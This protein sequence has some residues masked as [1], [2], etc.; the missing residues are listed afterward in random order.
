MQL[1]VLSPVFLVLIFC[2]VDLADQGWGM[3]KAKNSKQQQQ[4]CMAQ[5]HD[6]GQEESTTSC[7][8]QCTNKTEWFVKEKFRCYCDSDCKAFEDCCS[9]YCTFCNATKND[10]QKNFRWKCVKLGNYDSNNTKISDG[11]WMVAQCASDWPRDS[12][13]KKYKD[14]KEATIFPDIHRT[15]PIL[16]GNNITFRNVYCALCNNITDAYDPWTFDIATEVT[17]PMHFNFTE[18]IHFYIAHEAEFRRYR[19]EPHQ[20]RRYCSGGPELHIN[21]K[22]FSLVLNFQ[23]FEGRQKALEL[24]KPKCSTGL[25][26]DEKLQICTINWLPPSTE[27]GP[28]R[29]RVIFWLQTTQK[30]EGGLSKTSTQQALHAYFQ[31]FP[32]NLNVT[33]ITSKNGFFL[34]KSTLI[35]TPEQSLELRSKK[36]DKNSLPTSKFLKLIYFKNAWEM[37]ISNRTFKVFKTTSRPLKCFGISKVYTAGE[38]V[39]LDR[40]KIFVNATNNTYDHTNYFI[41]KAANGTRALGNITVCEKYIPTSCKLWKVLSPGHFKIL[42]NL[43]IYENSTSSLYDYGKYEVLGNSIQICISLYNK[44]SRH[45]KTIGKDQ[46][47]GWITIVCFLVSII[48][49]LALLTTYTMF[50]ELRK[51][52]GKNLMNLATSSLMSALFWLISSFTNPEQY[53]KFC[54]ATIIIQHYSL[55]ASFTSMSVISFHTCKTFARNMLPPKSSENHEGKLFVIYLTLIWFF[56]AIFVGICFL[57]DWKNIMI[58]GYG[59]SEVCWFRQKDAYMYFIITPNAMSLLFNIV[60]FLTAAFY[61]HKHS[62]N[63]A[64]RESASMKRSNFAIYIKLCSLMG[65]TWLF[66]L[67]DVL[68]GSSK[69]LGY[70]FVILT[71]LQGVFISIAFVFKKNTLRMYR[72]MISSRL[73]SSFASQQHIWNRNTSLE[74]VL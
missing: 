60:T 46:V 53:P 35:L 1:V 14:Y 57:L 41:K 34:V 32:E 4:M 9:D 18:Q 48:S 5:K 47:L 61:L 30:M 24:K 40:E 3:E 21:P 49:L 51:L 10:H 13:Y 71:C 11:V 25:I 7:R 15:V 56:P 59:D 42:E 16:N 37:K 29:Y 6:V 64:A 63:M 22:P 8:R 27:T 12:L 67:L 31:L 38:Y 43:S 69:I 65:F 20:H 2:T 72:R 68:V 58:L 26:F 45:L 44:Y 39:I 66:G 23:R 50:S 70:L 28:E 55:L 73:D 74:T 19:P 17:A 54:T 36:P 52:P 33:K 62:R